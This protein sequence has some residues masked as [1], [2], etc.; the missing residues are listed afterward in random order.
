MAKSL[1]SAYVGWFYGYVRK[2]ATWEPGDAVEPGVVGRFDHDLIF[3]HYKSLGDLGIHF[4]TSPERPVQD[5]LYESKDGFEFQPGIKAGARD[6]VSGLVDASE[7]VTL[8]SRREHASLLQVKN[9]TSSHLLDVDSVLSRIKLLILNN[10]WPL[11]WVVVVERI[12]V[13]EGFA[14]VCSDKGQRIDLTI[15]A[16]V[17]LLPDVEAYG[18]SVSLSAVSQAAGLAAYRFQRG[19]T[20]IFTCPI[21]VRR[22]LWERLLRKPPQLL[23]PSGAPYDPD[24]Q[25]TVANLTHVPLAQRYYD[26]RSAD[27]SREDIL[28]IPHSVLF[29]EL[30]EPIRFE[31]DGPPKPH[32][33]DELDLTDSGPD[34]LME[35]SFLAE[36]MRLESLFGPYQFVRARSSSEKDHG[37]WE[38]T[39]PRESLVEPITSRAE[40]S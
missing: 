20:P 1:S 15:G 34:D 17:G 36:H 37:I 30:D 27:I 21:R 16:G 25:L 40:R 33:R 8:I 23:D 3:Q 2:W 28:A 29:E 24:R 32:V 26:P 10:L 18:G 31:L 22:T 4:D 7:S 12:K 5:R 11:D 6:P 38:F 9:A 35:R 14:V 13:D 19:A 39:L